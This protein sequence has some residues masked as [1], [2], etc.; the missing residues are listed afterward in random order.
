ML[1]DQNAEFEIIGIMQG[2]CR[3][4]VQNDLN[5]ISPMKLCPREI[6]SK[7]SVQ[8]FGI[9]ALRLIGQLAHHSQGCRHGLLY[10][11]YGKKIEM[12]GRNSRNRFRNDGL[13]RAGNGLRTTTTSCLLASQRREG[14][15][16]QRK[17]QDD[18]RFHTMENDV[19]NLR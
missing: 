5:G 15:Y 6:L 14:E 8:S 11:F 19:A 12:S 4:A 7:A 17:K 9:D 2:F 16:Q 3:M 13:F 1:N 18:R 10:G